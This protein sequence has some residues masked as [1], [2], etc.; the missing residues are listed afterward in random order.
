MDKV[1]WPST[2]VF[3]IKQLLYRQ[4]SMRAHSIT[5]MANLGTGICQPIKIKE[6]GEGSPFVYLDH[7]GTVSV[8]DNEIHSR[9]F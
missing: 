1:C 4:C 5:D 9:A 6:R 2:M 7:S 3:Q 8:G